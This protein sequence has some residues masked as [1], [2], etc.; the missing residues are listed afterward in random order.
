MLVVADPALDLG[1]RLT[2][3]GARSVHLYNPSPVD[4]AVENT[5]NPAMGDDVAPTLQRG[6]VVRSLPAFDRGA[7]FDVRDGAYDFAFVPDLGSVANPAALLAR[8]RRVLGAEGALLAGARNPELPLEAPERRASRDD[9]RGPERRAR[10]IAY[11][12]LYDLASLQFASIR[13]LA[14][15]PFR[16]LVIAELGLEEGETPDVTVDTQ[17][18]DAA[19]DGRAPDAHVYFVLAAQRDVRLDTYAVLQLPD[20]GDAAASSSTA[21][22]DS[23]DVAALAAAQLRADAL[24]A[25]LEAEKA[26]SA[27]FAESRHATEARHV[28]GTSRVAELEA[29]LATRTQAAVQAE[30]RAAEHYARTER[31]T[32][33]VARLDDELGRERQRVQELTA[34]LGAERRERASE[35]AAAADD[36]ERALLAEAAARVA[37]L[38]TAYTEAQAMAAAYQMRAK[39]AEDALEMR[40]EQLEVALAELEDARA[41]ATA[42][43][44]QAMEVAE[45]ARAAQQALEERAR[46]ASEAATPSVD[47]A[48]LDA[49]AERATQAESIIAELETDLANIGELHSDE[50]TQLEKSL[51]ERGQ[52]VKSMEREITRRDRLVQE[53]VAA[54]EAA[55]E[56]AA[57]A[58]PAASTSSTSVSAPSSEEASRMRAKLEHLSME[59]ARREGEL[60]ARAWRIAE[61]EREVTLAK[62]SVAPATA[63]NGEG[64]HALR[65][66]LDALRQAL[67]QEHAAKKELEAQA[68]AEP[69]AELEEARAELARQAVLIDQLSRQLETRSD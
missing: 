52:A 30:A 23:A 47:P 27:R 57:H 1:A 14:Q 51:Q 50:L 53:L 49:L 54:L 20:A 5:A 37:Q 40:T 31:I 2:S 19:R 35:E 24:S 8:L 6:A 69:S 28:E 58:A 22:T 10:T 38:E 67:A 13:M 4:A 17:V 25:Q 45:V 15:M 68:H 62:Q 21:A 32:G 48:I 61:L 7:D 59:I 34:L 55:S 33:E 42:V 60:E 46:Q 12:D 16:G 36:R 43:S 26:A 64:D 18:A 66:E 39:S 65:A 9:Y 44:A 41:I 63:S 56:A 3:L 11:A 29:Q